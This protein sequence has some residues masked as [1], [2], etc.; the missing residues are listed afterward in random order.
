VGGAVVEGRRFRRMTA[1][2]AST[3]NPMTIIPIRF[4]LITV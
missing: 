3:S 2:V 4:T 1:M